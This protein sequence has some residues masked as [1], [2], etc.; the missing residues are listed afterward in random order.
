M[1][2]YLVAGL[3]LLVLA[4]QAQKPATK[5]STPLKT[6]RPASSLRTLTDSASYAIGISVASF[7][8]QQGMKN[9]NTAMVSKA[10][11]DVY[12]KKKPLLNEAEA[13]E[14]ITALM[15]KAQMD[16]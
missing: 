10:I 6:T 5:K 9:I 16:K 11:N 4:A 13:N 1:K 14:C 3:S 8:S 15:N 2:K 12:A 7:Y